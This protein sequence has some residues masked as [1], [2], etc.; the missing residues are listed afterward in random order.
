MKSV[1]KLKK[2]DVLFI[3]QGKARDKGSNKILLLPMGLIAMADYL[4]RN[5][6]KA[7]VVHNLI[8][9]HI[10]PS[11]DIVSL[12][13]GYQPRI[14][15]FDLHW[16][17]QIST[18]L[19]LVKY[20]KSKLPEA[21]V[22]L[23]GYTAS[24]FYKELMA[25]FACINY[26]IRGDSELPLFELARNVL[27]G[28]DGN[29]L[30]AVPNLVY[31]QSG[32]LKVNKQ[33]Y[34]LSAQLLNRLNFTRFDL[35]DNYK[36][37][38]SSNV[39]EGEISVEKSNGFNKNGGIFFYNCGRGC[40]YNCSICGGSRKS[41]KIISNRT[42]IVYAP[43]ASVVRNLKSL[44]KYNINTWYNTF[45]PYKNKAYFIELFKQ[46]KRNKIKLNLQFECLN[47]PS[48]EFILAVQD[49]FSRVRLDF[50][51][52]TG[53][54]RLRKLNKGNFYTNSQLFK[55]LRR[56]QNTKINV[57]LCFVAGLSF[58][59]KEDVFKTLE[60][61]NLVKNSFRRIHIVSEV[62]EMEP[63]S[64]WHLD[65]KKYGIINYRKT[66]ADFLEQH[67]KPSDLGYRTKKFTIRQIRLIKKYYNVE[68]N[69]I[70]ERSGYLDRLTK[71]SSPAR[72]SLDTL[73][74]LCRGCKR[75]KL[76]FKGQV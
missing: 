60:F 45:D 67:K 19:E 64:P 28:N 9:K 15:C 10:D 46:I 61:I 38:N 44:E 76:C 8:E 63:A 70:H 18:V 7:R 43:V 41:Q 3:H 62:L 23:G 24:F 39:F 14:I 72:F 74:K 49:T 58:E 33:S 21:T 5:G 6:I 65:S 4:E 1:R 56:L 36:I 57:D 35:L 42:Q 47:I 32:R 52:Q 37:Y 22:V 17:Q 75:Y 20:V 51:L 2:L 54:E 25:G 55:V 71:R 12:I 34:C 50:I 30:S 26:I 13:R 48:E 16:H 59:E 69:C 31:R 11:F 68:A 53:S 66:F 29:G 40:P 73:Y 27:S